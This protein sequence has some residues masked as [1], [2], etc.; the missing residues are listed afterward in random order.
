MTER[1]FWLEVWRALWILL[2]AIAKRWAFRF[3]SAL[4]K[5]GSKGD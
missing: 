5:R 2:D 3:D 4:E 1:E